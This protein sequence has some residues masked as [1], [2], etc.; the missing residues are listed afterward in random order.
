MDS[1]YLAGTIAILFILFR[2]LENKFIT[3]ENKQVKHYFR[4][5]LVVYLSVIGGKFIYE[6]VTPTDGTLIAPKVFTGDP[7]F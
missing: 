6:Q 2:F 7:E 3:K 1:M 5:A 4:E